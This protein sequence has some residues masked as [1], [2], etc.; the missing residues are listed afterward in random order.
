[1]NQERSTIKKMMDRFKLPGNLEVRFVSELVGYGVFAAETIKEG[2][3]I[4]ICYCIEVDDKI[5]YFIDYSYNNSKP[6]MALMALGCGS[7][8]NHSENANIKWNVCESNERFI[9]FYATRDIDVGEELC[10][11]YGKKYWIKRRKTFI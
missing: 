3:L 1:M 6:D 8:Y 11:N 2:S 10:H 7:I 9:E 4:E 5:K